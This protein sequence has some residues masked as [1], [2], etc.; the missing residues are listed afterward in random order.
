MEKHGRVYSF[1]LNYERTKTSRMLNN[2]LIR[3][4]WDPASSRPTL[5]RL[6]TQFK[7]LRFY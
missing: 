6:I 4:N 3:L 7:T 5:L 1:V 2:T